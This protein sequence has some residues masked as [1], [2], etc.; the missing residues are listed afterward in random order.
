[1]TTGAVR[2]LPLS[3]RSIRLDYGYVQY[4]QRRGADIDTAK[5]LCLLGF[6]GLLIGS[7]A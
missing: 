1:M 7:P 2:K 4:V 6:V 3:D 5:Y